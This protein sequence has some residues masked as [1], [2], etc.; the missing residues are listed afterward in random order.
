M[1]VKR[2]NG[3]DICRVLS[4]CGIIGL[5]VMNAGGVIANTD[6]LSVQG[7]LM[8]GLIV[9]FYPV[10]NIFGMM[11]GWLYISKKE[12]KNKNLIELWLAVLFYC[13]LI[14]T[15]FKIILPDSVVGIKE[16]IKV[17]F[18]P[19][20]GRYWYITCYTFM[21]LVIPYINILLRKLN[22][23]QYKK[24]LI[25]LFVLLSIV[26]TLGMQ[27]YFRILKGY[28]PFWLIYCYMVGGYLNLYGSAI[29]QSWSKRQMMLVLI[30]S[31]AG[32]LI[33]Q[34]IIG[35]TTLAIT[36]NI[37]SRTMMFCEYNSPLMVISAI[38]VVFTLA[39]EGVK[40][41]KPKFENILRLLSG[42]AF[43]VYILHSHPLVYNIL[44]S[45]GF[46]WTTRK[47]PLIGMMCVLLSVMAIYC[48]CF[49]VELVRIKIFKLCK[50]DLLAQKIAA[51]IDRLVS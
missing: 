28:S 29:K 36:G 6:F 33:S 18:P 39:S 7:I 15:L 37:S 40:I 13:F 41:G 20:Q 32:G 17:I 24:L 12:V 4:M 22:S 45:D 1:E 11:T 14:V 38:L 27:D 49:A 3:L 48:I 2:N 16:Y 10:V 46:I 25:L 5:H 31:S 34:Y 50:A 9:L 51:E 35:V 8:R 30:A 23:M 47:S 43:G 21:F 42:G 44:L 26:P 19:I